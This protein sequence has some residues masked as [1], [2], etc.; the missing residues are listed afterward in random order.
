MSPRPGGQLGPL[1][2]EAFTE[3]ERLLADLR[4]VPAG[5]AGHR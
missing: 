4:P 1:P 3:V 2:A 5:D